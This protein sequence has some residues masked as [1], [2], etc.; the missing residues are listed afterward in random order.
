[1][2]AVIH[3]AQNMTQAMRNDLSLVLEDL[4]D[5][6]ASDNEPP[7]PSPLARKLSNLFSGESEKH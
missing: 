5:I 3:I 6:Q 4:N 7:S 1:M 2:D